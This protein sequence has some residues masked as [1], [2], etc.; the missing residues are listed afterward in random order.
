[1]SESKSPVRAF[2]ALAILFVIGVGIASR[3]LHTGFPLFD[4][5]LGDALYAVM[6][7]L[8]L[9]LA[10]PSARLG[11]HRVAAL[12]LVLAIECFQL[13]GLPL[14]WQ[15]SDSVVLQALSIA[16]GT[17]FSA[18]DILAYVVGLASVFACDCRVAQRTVAS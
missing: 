4:K 9:R 6:L 10:S 15:S 5:Y 13:T 3:M 16:V 12:L 1:M 2:Y 14:A 7:Y 18:W 8:F 17:H 11:I